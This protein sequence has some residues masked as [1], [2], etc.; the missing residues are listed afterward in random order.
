MHI[1]RIAR[2]VLGLLFAA[3]AAL[4]QAQAWPSKPVR[5]IV[6]YPP[7]G[8]SDT[9]ARAIGQQLSSQLGQ[10]VV[11]E[12]RP[13]AGTLIGAEAAAR[14]TPDG[15]TIFSGDN[16]T[17]VFNSALYRKLPYDPQKD[18]APV[19][20]IARFPLLL[21]ANPAAGFSDTKD[22]IAKLKAAPGKFSYASVGAGSPHHLAMEMFKQRA[23]LFA[24]HIPYRG[25]GP[26]V[27]DVL[28]NQ[29]PMMMLDLAT[30]LPHLKSGKLQAL[31]VAS[32]SRLAQ[33]PNVPTLKELGFD[34]IEMYAWQGIAVPV[35]TPPEVVGR[36]NAEVN[37]A[38]AAPE[39]QKRLG[40][41]G[42]ELL[43]G[44]SRQMADYLQSETA[45]WHPLI[46]ERKITLD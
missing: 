14:S 41:L 32:G 27:Q 46:K 13:G 30:A 5:W 23:G 3:V 10:S 20:L 18:F 2:P 36:L 22:L 1:S 9:I 24:V 15:H 11:I 44:T 35:G 26:A 31:A 38:L 21:V 17:Y 37:K 40:E 45:R 43:G 39:V 29:V 6:P 42:V 19:A 12:N 34:D 7:G 28:G 33:Q 16:A 25:A 8:G 4:A